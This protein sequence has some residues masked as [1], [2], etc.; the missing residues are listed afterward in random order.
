MTGVV[1][2]TCIHV[3]KHVHSLTMEWDQ[4]RVDWDMEAAPH[5]STHLHTTVQREWGQMWVVRWTCIYIWT[6]V[7]SLKKVW[8]QS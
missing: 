6:H 5:W 3:V 8:N 1:S 7:H 4:K 2:W